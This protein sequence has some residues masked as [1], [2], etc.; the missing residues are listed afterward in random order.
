MRRGGATPVL[1]CISSSSSSPSN[2]SPHATFTMFAFPHSMRVCGSM[3]V[4][5]TAFD[6]G[7]EVPPEHPFHRFIARGALAPNLDPESPGREQRGERGVQRPAR[8]RCEKQCRPDRPDRVRR[9]PGCE[10]P[11]L[12]RP[13][14]NQHDG[15]SACRKCCPGAGG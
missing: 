14:P 6:A 15:G 13:Y 10:A 7:L 12:D 4:L 3:Y 5:G 8:Q 2:F 1:S 11:P 9:G